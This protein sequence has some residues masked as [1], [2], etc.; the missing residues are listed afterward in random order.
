MF[1]KIGVDL[2]WRIRL[3]ESDLNSSG[4]NIIPEN[5]GRYSWFGSYGIS[6]DFLQNNYQEF[7]ILVFLLLKFLVFS[8]VVALTNSLQNF[9][10]FRNRFKYAEILVVE[11]I[12]CSSSMTI[13]SISNLLSY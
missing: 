9:Y 13:S 5:M 8:C 3:L 1:A 7:F 12:A 4:K 11:F 6:P 10:V 2:T